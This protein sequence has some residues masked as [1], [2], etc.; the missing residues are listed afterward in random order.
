MGHCF[1]RRNRTIRSWVRLHLTVL[2]GDGDECGS[3]GGPRGDSHRCVLNDDR[4][5]GRRS[6]HEQTCHRHHDVGCAG[7]YCLPCLRGSMRADCYGRGR[8]DDLWYLFHHG[9]GRGVLRA[10]CHRPLLHFPRQSR[11]RNSRQDS[12]PAVLRREKRHA[13]QGRRPGRSHLFAHRHD[14]GID[15]HLVRFSPRHRRVHGGFDHGGEVLRLAHRQQLPCSV[16][17][18]RGRRIQLARAVLLLGARLCYP[19]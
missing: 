18:H 4:V 12:G 13:V 7:R 17:P 19:H 2:A 9:Q 8:D 10:R 11:G 1:H 5:E 3:H 15:R 14:L 16:A 6:C